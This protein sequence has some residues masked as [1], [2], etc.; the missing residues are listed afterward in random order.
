MGDNDKDNQ[1]KKP[2]NTAEEVHESQ[3]G[4]LA[5]AMVLG[6]SGA[7]EG[8]EARGQKSMV[9]SDTLPIKGGADVMDGLKIAGVRFG[10]PVEGDALFQYVD[11]PPGWKK[12]P[13]DHSMWS[14]LVDDKGR[15][16]AS[17]F[18]KAA[19]Y[20]RSAHMDAARRFDYGK[21]YEREKKE[22]VIVY[23]VTDCGKIV[24]STD[25]VPVPEDRDEQFNLEDQE[26]AKA[27]VWLEDKYPDWKDTS[28]YWDE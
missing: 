28:A 2:V 15:V 22:K 27:L 3:G 20:D 7:I 12:V 14:N 19:F 26:K 8:Q 9:N 21:D 13:T 10:K 16:R 6:S 5:E 25:P 1:L 18:Y 11:L 24:F 23:N 4:F 17:I